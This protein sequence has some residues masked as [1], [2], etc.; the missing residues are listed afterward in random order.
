M[1]KIILP[2]L[3]LAL[4][5]VIGIR[6]YHPSKQIPFSKVID[7]SKNSVY[8]RYILMKML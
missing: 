8:R 5:V 7:K 2:A 6:I 3:L 4:I 1:K